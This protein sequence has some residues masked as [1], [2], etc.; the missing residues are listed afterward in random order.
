M[1]SMY[2]LFP[3]LG[4]I[5]IIFF[6]IYFFFWKHLKKVA[7]KPKKTSKPTAPP[8]NSEAPSRK[9]NY[10]PPEEK[11]G[12]TSIDQ[13]LEPVPA[14]WNP[15]FPKWAKASITFTRTMRDKSYNDYA[16]T[17][18]QPN[19]ETI[20]LIQSLPVAPPDLPNYGA[21][22]STFDASA[23]DSIPWD[24][25]NTDSKQS[26]IVW[27]NVSTEAS[28]SIFL[29]V[30]HQN[31][32]SDVANLNADGANIKYHSPMMGVSTDN[33]ADAV[34]LQMTDAIG[35][36]AG[37]IAA[38]SA[39][40]AAE[41][42]WG[43]EVNK[44]EISQITKLEQTLSAAGVATEKETNK[45][46][47]MKASV[48]NYSEMVATEARETKIL[49]GLECADDAERAAKGL[50]LTA[51]E[52]AAQVAHEAKNPGARKL[53]EKIQ[54]GEKKLSIAAR[55]L[56]PARTAKAAAMSKGL[57]EKIL[58]SKF[59][60]AWEKMGV[61]AAITAFLDAMAAVITAGAVVTMGALAPFAAIIDAIAI[62]WN[63]LDM[64]CMAV[65][66]MLMLL[67]PA[68]LDKG[69]ANG[70]VCPDGGKPLDILIENE[71][72]YFIF[73]TFIPIGGVLDAFGPYLCYNPDGSAHMKQP[74]YIPAYLS[75]ASLSL[76]KHV[77]PPAQEPRG[78]ATSY[79]DPEHSIPPGWTITAGIA[80]EPC[81]PG[82]WTSSDVD[83]LC[84]ISTYVPRTY[85]KKSVVPTTIIKESYVPTTTAKNTQITTYGRPDVGRDI[86]MP[87]HSNCGPGL[88][89]TDL[90][91]NNI[92]DCWE[93]L[94]CNTNCSGSW[95][96][97]TWRCNTSCSGCGCVKTWSWEREY[98]ENAGYE[99]V[100]SLCR[101]PCPS[102][103]AYIVSTDLT[104]KGACSS[105]DAD[106][107]ILPF[108]TANNCNSI[109]AT[110]GGDWDF[111]AGVCWQKCDSATEIDVGALCRKKC[112]SDTTEV[113][114]V[115]WTSCSPGWLDEGALCRKKCDGDTPDDVAGVC[116][117]RGCGNDIDVGALCRERCRSGF[118]EV[119]GVC[120]G[121]I[122][123]YARGAMIPKSIKTYD[124]GY[125]PPKLLA[126][127]AFPWCNFAAPTMLNRMAQFYYDQST[128]NP[129][130]LDDGRIS[131]E[132]IVQFYGVIASSELSCDVACQ[133]K[134]VVFNPI[135][136]GDYEE[137]FGTTYPE[138]PGNEVSYR[139]FYFININASTAATLAANAKA[140]PTMKTYD[141]DQ[142]GY[143]TVT[144]CT[145]SDYTAP[146]AANKSTDPGTDPLISLPKFWNII[147]KATTPVQFSAMDFATSLVTVG[148]TIAI[149][150]ASGTSL[151]GQT[152]GGVGGGMAGEALNK[153]MVDALHI[154]QPPGVAVENAIIGTPETGYSVATNNDNFNINHGPI[155]EMRAMNSNGYIPQIDFCGQ[156]NTTSLLCSQELILRDTIDAYHAQNPTKHVKTVHIIEPRA[157]DGCYYKWNTVSYD[158]STNT[159]GSV[160]TAEEVVRQ[161]VITD[162][163]TCVFTPTDTF[164]KDL[165]N[166]PIR[167][168]YDIL[169]SSTKYPTR[170]L[171]STATVQ[172]RYIR[173]RPSQSADGYLRISQ[174]AV[175]DPTNTNLALKRPVY[176]TNKYSTYGPPNLIVDGT[177]SCRSG[178]IN[179]WANGT[180]S[181][182]NDYIEIDLGKN[183]FISYVFF[184]GRLDAGTD[185]SSNLGMRVE[186]LYTNEAT[187]IP[188]K[189][190]VTTSD[191]MFQKIDFS[192]QMVLPK[193]PVQPFQV[194]RPLPV[195]TNL[196]S[197]C[198]TR[199]QDKNQINDMIKAYNTINPT[200]PII[201][202]SKAITPSPTRCDYQVDIL[203]TTGAQKIISSENI[204]MTVSPASSTA[205]STAVVY[206][207][208]VRIKPQMNSLYPL[209][210]SQ[211]VIMN[212]AGINIA[213]NKPT[214][215]STNNTKS[216][217][218]A[219]YGAAPL[220]VD[221]TASVRT[222][223][224]FWS[225]D[226]SGSNITNKDYIDIDLGISCDIA[227]ITIY[228]VD[229]GAATTAAYQGV[230]MQVLNTLDIDAN[231]VYSMVLTPSSNQ[232]IFK[233]PVFNKC[234][235]NYT[236]LT[237]P[238]SYIQDNT[239]R[240]NNVDNSGG[241]LSFKSI[242][243][244]IV[245]LFN[246]IVNPIKVADPLGALGS[247]ISQADTTVNNILNASVAAL[248]LQGCPNTKCSDPA[249]LTA[250]MNRYNNDNNS[251]IMEYGTEANIMTQVSKAG[252]AGPS[253]CDVMFTNLY[254]LYDDYLYPPINTEMST[255]IK[256]FTM[257]DTGSCS[258]GVAPGATSIID[259]SMNAI[260]IIPASSA[261]TKP[262]STSPCQINCRD[263]AIISSV[264][265]KLNSQIANPLVISNFT[266]ITQSFANG[267]STCEYFM[268]KDI[269]TTNARTNAKT[270]TKNVE[271]YAS[272]SFTMNTAN[273]SF[274]LNTVQEF[275]PDIITTSIDMVTGLTTAIMNGVNI[276]L[277]FLFSYDNTTPSPLVNETPTIL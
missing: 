150:A 192:T 222:T 1:S 136:G 144:G 123:T 89:D 155:Y 39:Y 198:P 255:M 10:E 179:N 85:A 25:D 95:D 24:A 266:T 16:A 207:H 164:I 271:T 182:Q 34:V 18:L 135:T 111:V 68:L 152:V 11:E 194:P 269:T 15:T 55:I 170:D 162:K 226:L 29:K 242:T 216:R 161:Y 128:L 114:G 213:I 54:K 158:A 238:I 240:L 96:P 80:R 78:D 221:G 230:S 21:Q 168:Y 71:F 33:A 171:Q 133:M 260:G 217:N 214:Y 151:K 175:F 223:P 263:P 100:A 51:D 43:Q 143:F 154:Q 160:A 239:P 125:N 203:R 141:A 157:K 46:A 274:A 56:G 237:S 254:S 265:T 258:M 147:E 58:T 106:W 234:T 4:I 9:T 117:Q 148:A 60:L 42:I 197:S 6:I 264:K 193:M 236:Q 219:K 113:A 81:L 134:T 190:I 224:K 19:P 50:L 235:F 91:G 93:D 277:P 212:A 180:G 17:N 191:S 45:L 88:R 84:N 140:N 196:G 130:T 127:V 14:G 243:S 210:I 228:G 12:F 181:I 146:D 31:L 139:R 13:Q 28:K 120:W 38:T 169:S 98:C 74:L 225:N 177:L 30:Y 37:Q 62:A 101:S 195:E 115:C 126:N 107:G 105:G 112:S 137:S 165:T 248:Q 176:A 66:M 108:C 178:D 262:F 204:Y 220:I 172:G 129:Q 102:G 67:L 173:I 270:T 201:K 8:D 246:S 97:T 94:R 122:G 163:S 206:G 20:A 142:K 53:S 79:T 7:K 227:S 49:K 166:Y 247:Q 167:S 3:F 57:M 23:I 69:L 121:D 245:D 251:N 52:K 26:D 40:E 41:K 119:A 27:G 189:Q 48:E 77:Y 229:Q 87:K 249:V 131:Y 244:A 73:T 70:G 209:L 261:L 183:Y 185:I 132:Y 184:Y 188:Q 47:K 186:V 241:V 61:M 259:V 211:V 205:D 22:L 268:K 63:A 59:A 202:V 5:L 116:W 83:M 215:S 250:I 35:A 76:Y 273:C 110:K 276:N 153:V 208:Y 2:T 253:S 272:A 252:I 103:T 90:T 232:T 32:M 275:D 149:G 267:T 65:M 199:C 218:S 159:E 64:I 75:D 145:N 124:P 118:H 104:C 187:A 99:K 156:I 109:K 92:G 200:A 257:V 86:K 44:Y 138:D 231:P 36:V 233:T 256:R 174:I 72:L 82:T